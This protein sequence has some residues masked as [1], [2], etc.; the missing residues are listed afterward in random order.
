[1]EVARQSDE[2]KVG[3]DEGNLKELA[4]LPLNG[5]QVSHKNW[6]RILLVLGDYD[7]E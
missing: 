1:M 3:V 6:H 4:E 2:V 5:R 7:I